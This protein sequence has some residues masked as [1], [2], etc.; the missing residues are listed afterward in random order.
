MTDLR[1]AVAML[2]VVA[3]ALSGC[4]GS[5]S[6]PSGDVAPGQDGDPGDD[7]GSS[8]PELEA[9]PSSTALTF[10]AGTVDETLWDNGT[11]DPQAAYLPAGIVQGIATEEY[12]GRAIVEL[13]AELPAGIP[14]R[15]HAEATYD[16]TYSGDMFLWLAGDG[17]RTYR[18]STDEE[19][20]YD[21]GTSEATATLDATV[22]RE[23]GGS[24]DLILSYSLPDASDSVDYSLR[25][26]LGADPGTVP[27]NV[28]AA[29]PVED[30]SAPITLR[31][32][33]ADQGTS[34]TLWDPDD[35]AVAMV[36]LSGPQQVELPEEASAGEYVVLADDDPG[37]AV[38]VPGG[39]TLR[40]LA[41]EAT[42]TAATSEPALAGPATEPVT[43]SFEV[44]TAPVAV[45]IALEPG[46]NGDSVAFSNA[47]GTVS[48]PEGQVLSFDSTATYIT[49]GETWMSDLGGSQLV[50]G[51]YEAEFSADAAANLEIGQVVVE[52]VR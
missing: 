25:A 26:D 40:A 3:G 52:Y 41:T 10:D 51:T 45:G 17:Y 32:A 9:D 29:F 16:S 20:E 35:R 12:P 4:L 11:F 2:V 19:G 13:T 15:V 49:S 14:V 42:T 24:V 6:S 8:E 30:P 33:A 1:Y 22:V 28:P 21:S 43:W 27:G 46:P 5:S 50:E 31:P 48:S 18:L 39:G 38:E 36:D 34:V 23:D 7:P 47:A 44:P 37:V